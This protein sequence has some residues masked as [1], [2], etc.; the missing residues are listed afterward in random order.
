MR[1]STNASMPARTGARNG[2]MPRRPAWPPF[3][4]PSRHSLRTYIAFADRDHLVN[5][6]RQRADVDAQSAPRG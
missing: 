1:T 3:T 6:L 5:Y 4:G 2:R